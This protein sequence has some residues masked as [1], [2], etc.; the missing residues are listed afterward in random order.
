[1]YCRRGERGGLTIVYAPKCETTST[2]RI[3]GLLMHELGHAI[4]LAEGWDDHTERDAD[5]LARAAFGRRVHYD[6]GDVQTTGRGRKL[7]PRHLPA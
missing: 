3:D 6:A 2:A 4:A 1:M 5:A 7:R